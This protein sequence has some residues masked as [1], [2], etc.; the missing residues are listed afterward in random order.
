[1]I[2]KAGRTAVGSSRVVVVE[3]VVA[4]EDS[5]RTVRVG[6]VYDKRDFIKNNSRTDVDDGKYR[7][8]TVAKVYA[9]EGE[10]AL[11]EPISCAECQCF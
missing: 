5:R 8:K 10:Y 3:I 11:R 1:L 6:A 9:F 7:E 4:R 2:K